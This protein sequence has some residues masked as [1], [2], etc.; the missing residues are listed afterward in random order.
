MKYRCNN[1]RPKRT[2]AEYDEMYSKIATLMDTP[3]LPDDEDAA[4]LLNRLVRAVVEEMYHIDR[5]S[6]EF[7][8][9]FLVAYGS[10]NVILKFQQMPDEEVY[11]R[12]IS[13][14]P[15][16]AFPKEENGEKNPVQEEERP[17]YVLCNGEWKPEVEI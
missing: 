8:E 12:L 14:L 4:I 15:K 6:T 9:M 11:A 16:T 5:Y 13:L 1:K 2:A 7:R 10:I 17:G 3:V